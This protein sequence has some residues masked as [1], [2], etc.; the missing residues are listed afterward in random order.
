MKGSR[1]ASLAAVLALVACATLFGEEPLDRLNAARRSANV[2]ELRPDALLSAAAQRYAVQLSDRGILSHRG[3][4]GSSALDRYRA[5]GGTDVRVGE[6]LGAG[7]A[8]GLVQEAWMRSDEHRKIALAPAW[9]H[10]G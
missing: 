6:I 3:D 10:A 1:S 4:D 7:P 2:P 5:A 8:A 9:T